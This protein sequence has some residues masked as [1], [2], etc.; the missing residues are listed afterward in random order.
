LADDLSLIVIIS[1]SNYELET[2]W[3]LPQ[4]RFDS[5]ETI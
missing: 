4:G 3:G 1:T 5:C 2:P